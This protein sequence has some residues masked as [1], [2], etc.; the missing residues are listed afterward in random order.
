MKRILGLVL[1]LVLL[2]G[3]SVPAAAQEPLTL[4]MYFPVN[5]G[6]SAAQLI[7]SM[8]EEFNAQNPGVQVE[9]VYTGNYDD[10]V[11]AI[12]TAIQGG[13]PPRACS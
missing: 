2:A 1:A 6:G 5:V 11:T 4:T 3:L 12:Q 10:T 9:A 8:T 7:S 13:N